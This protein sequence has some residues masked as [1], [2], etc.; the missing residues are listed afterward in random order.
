MF[1]YKKSLLGLW[2]SGR[3]ATETETHGGKTSAAQTKSLITLQELFTFLSPAISGT[4]GSFVKYFVSHKH[5][6]IIQP[7]WYLAEL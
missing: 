5:V 3:V 4:A 2:Q 7:V 6:D 1:A